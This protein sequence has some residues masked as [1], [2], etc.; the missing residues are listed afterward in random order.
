M[1]DLMKKVFRKV[2]SDYRNCTVTSKHAKDIVSGGTSIT[3]SIKKGN[4][5]RITKTDKR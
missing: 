2:S 1:Y 5:I 3:E 4:T